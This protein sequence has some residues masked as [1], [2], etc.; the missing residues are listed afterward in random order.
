MLHWPI[1]YYLIWCREKNIKPL[2]PELN[3]SA[4]RCLTRFFI[5]DF[6]SRT[7]HFVNICVKSQQI[8]QLFIQFINY[9]SIEHLSEGTRN[10][11]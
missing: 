4:Q 9:V 3:P 8:H 7:V 5:G 1:L 6:A 10:A 11:P 2:T